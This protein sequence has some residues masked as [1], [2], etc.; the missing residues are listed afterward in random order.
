MKCLAFLALMLLPAG[1]DTILEFDTRAAGEDKAIRHWGIDATW[2]SPDNTRESMTHGEPLI[3]FVRIGVYMHRPLQEDGSLSDAQ[4]AKLTHAL[5]CAE[6][7][8][9]DVPI[10][11]SPHNEEGIIGWY[12]NGDGSAHL[13]RWLQAI[14]ATREWVQGKGHPVAMIEAFNEPDY[15]KW[16]MG[17]REDLDELSR[18]MKPWQVLRVG[19]S[20]MSTA[21]AGPWYGEIHRHVD[22]GSTHTLYGTMREFIDFAKEV[23]RDR[24]QLFCPEAHSIAEVMVGAE[25]GVD[26]AAWWAAISE[27][28]GRFMR[29]C[30]GKRL[31]YAAVEEN[32]SAGS[33]Y[34]APDGSLHAF[35]GATERENGI[36]TSYRIV[37][38]NEDVTYFPDGDRENGQPRKRGEAY[39]VV[40]KPAGGSISRWIEIVPASPA[41]TR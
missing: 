1:A 6:I 25:V 32:W 2:A 21:S 26:Y 34:R 8:A 5:G 28:R 35:V 14:A 12:K 10:M 29:A 13:D 40:A 11:L 36:T 16:N 20:T 9:K 38:R 37:C 3:D 4:I 31:A 22:I 19:P 41:G 27:A 30:Q 39:E 18:R 33:V 23:K 15:E 17:T 24:N 7:V